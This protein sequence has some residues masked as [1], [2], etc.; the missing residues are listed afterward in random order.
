MFRFRTCTDIREYELGNDVLDCPY[1][2][3]KDLANLRTRLWRFSK[4]EQ[5]RLINWGYAICDVA[6][7]RYVDPNFP[8]EGGVG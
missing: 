5:E 6:M 8:Y 3:T 2:K 1:D 4:Q 7:R